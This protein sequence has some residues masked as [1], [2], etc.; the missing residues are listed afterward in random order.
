MF[1]QKQFYKGLHLFSL[2]ILPFVFSLQVNSQGFSPSVQGR[3]QYI[4]DSFQNNPANPYVG[5]MSAAINVDGLAIWQGATGFAARNYNPITNELLPGGTPFTVDKI[6]RMYSVTKTFTAP[7]VLELAREGKLQLDV[8]VTTYL[9]LAAINPLLNTSVTVRQ[10]LAH[11]SGYSDYTDEI[12]LQIAV[13]FDPNHVW[14]PFEMISFVHQ[15]NAP[16]AVRKYSSTNYIMLGAI[17]EVAT[18]KPVEQHFRERFFTPLH[19]QSMYLEVREPQAGH[20]DLAAPHENISAFN[21]IFAVT[22]QPLFPNAY[23]NISQFPMTGVASLAFTGGGLISNVGEL[24]E[25]GN[26]LFGGRAT[27]KSTINTMMNSISSTPDADGDYLGYGLWTNNKVS[28]SD[29][30]VGHNGSAPGYRSVMMYQPDRQMTIAVMSNYGGANMY[31]VAKR[32]Y[33]V[34]PGFLCGNGNKKESKILLCWKGKDMCVARPAADGFMKKGAYLGSCSDQNLV[35]KTALNGAIP[36]LVNGGNEARFSIYPNPLNRAAQIQYT[37]V[38][39]GMVTISLYNQ[40]GKRVR[41]IFSERMQ[42]G[43]T[44][45]VT[46]NAEGLPKG[47]YVCL[48]QTANGAAQRKMVLVQ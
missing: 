4:L 1:M 24:A 45:Q 38:E 26:A 21:P 8:A 17:I 30:F 31:A 48:I 3:L 2:L 18:G 39:T 40:D 20:G 37:A 23:T 29:Y 10:L 35:T 27:S 42:G 34:L 32:L 36:S 14:T 22:G 7:L 44:K 25:W 13:A 43:S 15:I 46:I 19:F 16:G 28:T 12:G 5:G 6:S 47:S 41:V 11:E 33:E 9:P